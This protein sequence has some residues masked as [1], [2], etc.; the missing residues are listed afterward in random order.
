[1]SP[2]QASDRRAGARPPRVPRSPVLRR[3]PAGGREP[4]RL[5]NWS[6]RTKLIVVLLIPTV[7]AAVLIALRF[8]GLVTRANHLDGLAAQVKVD[9]AVAKVV[10]SL[11]DERRL[12][13]HQ[14]I[15]RSQASQLAT[16]Q[17]TVDADAADFART[18]ADVGPDLPDGAAQALEGIK[19]QLDGLQ[20]LRADVA[21]ARSSDAVMRPYGRLIAGMLAERQ[22]SFDA[23]ERGDMARSEAAAIALARAKEQQSIAAAYIDEGLHA[24]R[25]DPEHRRQ[26][27][28]AVSQAQ[29]WQ[30]DFDQF[31]SQTTRE[32]YAHTVTASAKT[33]DGLQRQVLERAE[34]GRRLTGIDAVS[35]E[36][37]SLAAEASTRRAESDVE[38]DISTR[39]DALSSDADRHAVLDGLIV[40]L[41]LLVAI[42]MAVVIGRSLVRPLHVLRRAA[43]EVAERRLPRAVHGMLRGPGTVDRRP[44]IAPVPVHGEDEV[45][46]VARA[47]DAVHAEAVRLAAEQ[48]R[49]RSTVNEMFID[50]ARRGQGLIDRQLGVLDRMEAAETDPDNLSALFELDHLATRSRRAFENLLVLTGNDFGR[51]LPGPV[52]A[53]EVIGAA[54]SEIEDYRSVELREAPDVAVRGDAVS[55]VVHVLSELLEN[56]TRAAPDEKVTVSSRID[57]A[58]RWLIEVVDRGPGIGAKE[59]AAI[60]DRLARAQTVDVGASKRMGFLVVARLAR[61]HG[62]TVRLRPG[63]SRG[64]I[65]GVLVPEGLLADRPAATPAEPR[66]RPEGR[67]RKADAEDKGASVPSGEPARAPIV[68]AAVDQVAEP[69]RHPLED[70]TPTDRMPAYRDLLTKWFVPSET[71][72]EVSGPSGDVDADPAP[73]SKPAEPVSERPARHD[74]QSSDGVNSDVAVRNGRRPDD[75]APDRG[76]FDPQTPSDRERADEPNASSDAVIDLADVDRK[77]RNGQNKRNGQRIISR[78]PEDILDRI[79][80]MVEG[81]QRARQQRGAGYPDSRSRAR[82][83]RR[84]ADDTWSVPRP[85]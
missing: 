29:A 5:H 71:T 39:I 81:V 73:A 22:G 38:R 42:G 23:T 1:M 48:A 52:A 19:A 7:T 51:E 67:E 12:T 10:H 6:V 60:N 26:V 27:V 9:A 84:P 85:R 65:A 49:L 32:A 78:D 4:W 69:P 80:D 16:Q 46:Q 75:D 2:Q 44:K 68:A 64:L 56:S 74:E 40:G 35:W 13:V 11:Q 21:G 70:E 53:S 57:D 25:L 3:P 76:S 45:G 28:T 15:G 30:T 34:N 63:P 62:I 77:D 41:L 43:F 31:A 66:G 20:R 82:A 79:G 33:R 83:T 18:V 59:L 61:R 24:G 54:L 8:G 50:L 72:D 55:D 58:G 36:K 17:N 14:A 47:F 37:A